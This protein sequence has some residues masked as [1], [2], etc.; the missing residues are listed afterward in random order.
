MLNHELFGLG[1]MIKEYHD[2]LHTVPHGMFLKQW[3]EKEKRLR[4][5]L[6]DKF[7]SLKLRTEDEDKTNT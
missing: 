1:D 7:F 3:E 4:E 5:D 2:F 6:N